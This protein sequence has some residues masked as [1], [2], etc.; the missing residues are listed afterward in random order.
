MHSGI[1]AVSVELQMMCSSVSIPLVV[2]HSIGVNPAKPSVT[3]VCNNL[4][5]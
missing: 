3:E 2:Q 5:K 1:T 4:L